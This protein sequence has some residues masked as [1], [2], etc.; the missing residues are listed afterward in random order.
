MSAAQSALLIE[1]G[2]AEPFVGSWRLAHDPVASRGIPAHI[3]ALFP[4]KPPALL[5]A[6]CQ[7]MVAR[8]VHGIPALSF[9][10]TALE[11]FP[12]ALWLKPEPTAPFNALTRALVDAFPDYP[13]YGGRH[14]TVIPHLTIAMAT[15]A[16]QRAQ[17]RA[18]FSPTLDRILPLA[19]HAADV[20]LYVSD[21]ARIWRRV[22]SFPLGGT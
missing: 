21:E 18:Q 4:F 9:H 7:E 3:T 11:E 20:A 8:I 19:V 17:L 15:E 6:P 16:E 1:V 5:D 14:T 12:D 13:P 10:L 2:A 22:A